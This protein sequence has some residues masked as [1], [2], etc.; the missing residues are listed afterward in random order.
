MTISED[1]KWNKNTEYLVEKAYSRMELLSKAAEFTKSIEDK[2][3]IYIL[4]IRS[5][6]KT[7]RLKNA[8]IP[9]EE[10]S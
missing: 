4:Y 6:Q 2:R 9:Y 8:S 1:L 10:I 5:L 3:E 7:I